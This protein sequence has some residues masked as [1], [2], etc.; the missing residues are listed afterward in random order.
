MAV[1]GEALGLVAGESALHPPIV[2]GPGGSQADR[3]AHTTNAQQKRKR[4]NQIVWCLRGKR[5]VEVGS[6]PLPA[7]RAS[8]GPCPGDGTGRGDHAGVWPLRFA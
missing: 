3:D 5:G 6:P 4:H 8:W 2:G 1:L 7:Y